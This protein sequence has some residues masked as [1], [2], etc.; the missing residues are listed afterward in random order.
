MALVMNSFIRKL[1]FL[2][3]LIV[4]ILVIIIPIKPM[5]LG[6]SM[7]LNCGLITGFLFCYMMEDK[8]K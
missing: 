8:I 4:T 2:I 1:L 6:L 7:S 3:S 5:I